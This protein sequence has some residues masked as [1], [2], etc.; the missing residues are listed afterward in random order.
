MLLLLRQHA[1]LAYQNFQLTPF[2][3]MFGYPTGVGA[4]IVKKSFLKQLRRPWFT[5]GTTVDFVQAPGTVVTPALNLHE[6]FEVKIIVK[7]YPVNLTSLIRMAPLI[8]CIS[9]L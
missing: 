9:R 1:I 2:Y 4:L 7:L 5:G 6:Q 8:T 3:K